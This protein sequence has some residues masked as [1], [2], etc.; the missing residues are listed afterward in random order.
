[1]RRGT[2]EVVIGVLL[3]VLLS[4]FVV[5]TRWVV[6]DL[7]REATRSSQEYARVYR[8]LVDTSE[9]AGTQALLDLS[10]SI[11]AQGVPLVV[12]DRDGVPGINANVPPEIAHDQSRL[13]A[14][15]TQLDRETVPVTDSLIGQI[16][17]GRSPLVKWLNIIPALQAASAFVLLMAAV[18]IIRTRGNAERERVWAGMARESAHQL[19]TPLSSLSGWIE[20]MEERGADVPTSAALVNMRADLVRLDRVAHRFERIGRAPRRDSVDAPALVD[21]I[22]TYFRAR[23][24]TLANAVTIDVR[25]P[26][27][28]LTIL[29]DAVLLEWAMEVLVKNAV[30]ALAGRGGTIT[31][32]TTARPEGGARISVV[33]DGPG[34][35][36]D[37]RGRIFDPG[38]ST[39]SSGWGI[40]LS[41][42]RRIVEENHGGSL[43]LVP[44]DRG[45]SFEII[46][47]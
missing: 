38:F 42:A 16:H 23:V 25:H 40:G 22:G 31:L 28:P 3:A 2:P 47:P 41:L 34:I 13:R 21:R 6:R 26:D 44:A 14:F 29:G 37:V 4:S 33:D 15:V 1:M 5:F 35:P 8:A 30:D 19:G 17:Y 46:L 9:F 24:P 43:R 36:R 11:V 32:S 10:K 39:K 27:E 18:Y 7:Q 45:A 20:L 12:T